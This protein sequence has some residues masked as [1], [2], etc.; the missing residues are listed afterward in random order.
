MKRRVISLLAIVAMLCSMVIVCLPAMAADAEIIKMYQA[1][2]DDAAS[3][4]EA[5]RAAIAANADANALAEAAK[6]ITFKADAKPR[7][8]YKAAYVAAGYTGTDYAIAL[9]EDWKAMMA[10][11]DASISTNSKGTPNYFKG[12]TFHLVQDVDFAQAGK[13]GMMGDG[14]IFSGNINGHG[15]GFDNFTFEYNKTSTTGNYKVG[16]ICMFEGTMQDFG[17]NSGSFTAINKA[18]NGAGSMELGMI[19]GFSYTNSAGHETSAKILRVWN[20]AS[21]MSVSGHTSNNIG[22][23]VG[24]HA[25]DTDAVINGFYTTVE[26]PI[27]DVTNGGMSGITTSNSRRVKV[28]NVLSDVQAEYLLVYGGTPGSDE[29]T[30][31]SAAL[32]NIY[33]TGAESFYVNYSKVPYE[34]DVNLGAAKAENAFEAAM[35][36]NA[37]QDATDDI[38]DVWFVLKDGKLR[39]GEK[40]NRIRKVTLTGYNKGVYYFN[41]NTAIDLA[42]EFGYVPG[43]QVATVTGSASSIDGTTLNLGDE[44]I[45]LN[46][47]IDCDHAEGFTYTATENHHIKTCKKACGYAEELPCTAQSYTNNAVTAEQLLAGIKATHSGTCEFC[48]EEFTLDCAVTYVVADKAGVDN[49]WDYS[50]CDCGRENIAHKGTADMLGGDADGDGKIDL[51]DAIRMLRMIAQQNV[52]G[53]IKNA[54]LNGNSAI[55]IT[56]VRL[57]VRYW[58]GDPQVIEEV[59]Q[60]QGRLNVSNLFNFDTADYVRINQDGTEVASDDSLASTAIAVKK[61]D[62]VTFGPVRPTQVVY[63]YAYDAEMNPIEPIAFDNTKGILTFANKAVLAS[64]EVP[65]DVAYI[66]LSAETEYAEKYVARF[67]SNMTLLEYETRTNA[68]AAEFTNILKNKNVLTVGDSICAAAADYADANGLKGWARYIAKEFDAKVTNS[69]VSGAA[70]SDCR[71]GRGTQYHQISNQIQQHV[72]SKTFDYILLHGGVNDAWDDV[73]VGEVSASFDPAT[74][75][76]TTYAGGME[77]AIYTAIKN[78]GDTAAI[79][80]LINF[81]SPLHEKAKDSGKYFEVGKEIC[82]KWGIKYLDLYTL[83]FDTSVYTGDTIHPNAAGYEVLAP[84]INGFMT[85]MRPVSYDIYSKVN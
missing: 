9:A 70:F 14:K 58:L 10:A 48:G 54:D 41:A 76:V 6:G 2:A 29:G 37:A 50:A 16:M 69:G 46:I 66:K 8:A 42:E 26:L 21:S 60:I 68:N 39:F 82:E 28:Y 13:I 15:Y 30:A 83:D 72:G 36:I 27:D 17:I 45:T 55:D 35:K 33:T 61:G 20:N 11:A 49:Y 24:Y 1:I 77:L 23:L 19:G 65:A 25:Q 81:N 7:F 32:K 53:N 43:G 44:D 57:V 74:F 5:L 52:T 63:G 71:I 34:N 62:K 18:T 59:E 64:Y 40:T 75:D 22:A 12:Y 78:Y 47:I 4:A 84:Y 38:E 51:L 79:G 56:E 85:E 31:K 73:N 67:N 80:Y 3:G